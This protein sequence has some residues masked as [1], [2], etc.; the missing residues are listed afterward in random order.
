MRDA[1]TAV[2]AVR[3]AD[4]RHLPALLSAAVAATAAART[5]LAAARAS[6]QA[7]QAAVDRARTELA[8]AE[9][10]LGA[11]ER[12]LE[13]HA[14]AARVAQRRRIDDAAPHD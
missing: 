2:D 7:A 9:P 11:V 14:D 1:D 8:A 3:P 10:A 12:A 4:P 5:R 13:R 6:A